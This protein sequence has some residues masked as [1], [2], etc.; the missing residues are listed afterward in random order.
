LIVDDIKA[1]SANDVSVST[2]ILADY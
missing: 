2:K 1:K